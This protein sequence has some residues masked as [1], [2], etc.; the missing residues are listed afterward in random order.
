[1]RHAGKYRPQYAG[2]RQYGIAAFILY[3]TPHLYVIFDTEGGA[4]SSMMRT[5]FP[6]ADVAPQLRLAFFQIAG[7]VFLRPQPPPEHD[8]STNGIAGKYMALKRLMPLFERYAPPEFAQAMR[9]LF[10]SLH[11]QTSGVRQDDD[12]WVQKGI[13]FILDWPCSRSA[14][15]TC[16]PATM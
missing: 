8:R 13:S 4:S 12:E 1:M 6:S 9:G 16:R 11:A 2:G 3:L 14:T 10:E 5:S 7:G 15:M